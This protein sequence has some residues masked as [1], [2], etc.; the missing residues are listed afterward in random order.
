M[1]I[2]CVFPF[3][4]SLGCSCSA[5]ASG[6]SSHRPRFKAE[7]PGVALELETNHR[8][9]DPDRRDVDAGF[10]YTGETAAPR[11]VTSREDT[12]LEET[13]YEEDLLPVCSPALLTARAAAG[14]G[15][16][17]GLAA[18]LRSRSARRPDIAV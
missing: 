16:P 7:H 13:L 14:P 18:A 5:G 10:A 3:L 4:Q 11:P 17:A 15:R 2:N 1:S 9:V 8:G 6:A 12:L